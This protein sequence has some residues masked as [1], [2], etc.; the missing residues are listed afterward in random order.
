MTSNFFLKLLYA[1]MLVKK[2]KNQNDHSES[3]ILVVLDPKFRIL[4]GKT[5]LQHLVTKF[6][7]YR[8]V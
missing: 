8:H 4:I 2:I 6:R 7:C 3:V 5:N 1:I